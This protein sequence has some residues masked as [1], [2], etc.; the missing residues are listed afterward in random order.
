MPGNKEPG[1]KWGRLDVV[2][3]IPHSAEIM[4]WSAG[5]KQARKQSWAPHQRTQKGQAV[6]HRRKSSEAISWEEGHHKRQALA[7]GTSAS[8]GIQGASVTS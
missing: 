6:K 2:V 7:K 5:L 4:G 8:Q 3:N 1:I